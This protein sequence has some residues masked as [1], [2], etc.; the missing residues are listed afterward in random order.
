MEKTF[1]NL[2][3]CHSFFQHY[4]LHHHQAYLLLLLD[5]KLVMSPFFYQVAEC[6]LPQE[7]QMHLRLTQNV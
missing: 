6:L 3:P 4:Q 2:L 1:T 5:C 7:E